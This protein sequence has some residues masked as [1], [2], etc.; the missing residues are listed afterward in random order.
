MSEITKINELRA[1]RASLVSESRSLLDQAHAA[2][3]GLNAEE[4]EQYDR[5]SADIDSLKATITLE[6]ET[7]EREI[8]LAELAE[9]RGFDVR[10]TTATAA[11]G[12]VDGEKRFAEAFDRYLRIDDVRELPREDKQILREGFL[13]SDQLKGTTTLGGYTV[14]TSFDGR[15]REHRVQAG[16]MRQTRV[17][18][19]QTGSGEDIQVPKTT[20]HGTANW[21]SE[22]N[23]ISPD[24]ENFGQVT[25]KSYV[26]AEIIRVSVQLLQDTGV[27]LEGYLAKALGGNIGRAQNT[28][29]VTGNGTGKPTGILQNTSLGFTAG[30][31]AAIATDDLL[32]LYY[33]VI[34]E[35][36]R[37]GEWV[38]A[39]STIKAVRKLKDSTGQYIWLPGLR[40]GEDDTL[41]GKRV[42]DDPDVPTIGT[43]NKSVIFG[44]MS[45]YTIRDTGGFV[46]RRLDER[47]AENLLVAFLAWTRTD[48]ILVDQTGA[49][50]HLVHP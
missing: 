16:A 31:A 47:Y 48:G 2:K 32:E 45:A 46:L 12:G 27:D 7:R 25:L 1:Q 13:R 33:S 4:R 36:R 29:Y 49:V 30:G 18:V 21:I 42:F 40:A 20:S 23:P 34:P 24:N 14:P 8:E 39:D 19:L 26:V 5:I 9:V 43:G 11:D 37:D 50:K 35:Y 44:D 3:R 15:L 28:A 6:E 10:D 41:L 22:G 38:M 17:N